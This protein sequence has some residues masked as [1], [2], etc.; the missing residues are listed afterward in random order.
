MEKNTQKLWG[1]AFSQKPSEAVIAF[2]AGR[3][4]VAVSPADEKLLPYDL[5]VNKAHCVMLAKIGIIPKS[6]AGKILKGL[7]ELEALAK[8]GKFTIDPAKEDVHTNI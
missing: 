6:D 5:W 3:D 2:T 1:A 4:V 8:T 7:V